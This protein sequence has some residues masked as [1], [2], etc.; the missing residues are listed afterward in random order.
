MSFRNVRTFTVKKFPT[1]TKKSMITFSRCWKGRMQSFKHLA[2]VGKGKKNT[3]KQEQKKSY[4]A[5]LRIC[6]SNSPPPPGAYGRQGP[7]PPTRRRANPSGSGDHSG[8]ETTGK[9][10]HLLMKTVRLGEETRKRR[11]RLPL[12]RNHIQPSR[13]YLRSAPAGAA[14]GASPAGRHRHKGSGSASAPTSGPPRPARVRRA[15]GGSSVP[16]RPPA[17]TRPPQPTPRPGPSRTRTR[18]TSTHDPPRSAAGRKAQNRSAGRRGGSWEVESR[19][20]LRGSGERAA[21]LFASQL[22]ALGATAC[23]ARSRLPSRCSP[24]VPTREAGTPRTGE[25]AGARTLR[26]RG[27]GEGEGSVHPSGGS[28]S[29]FS[30][31]AGGG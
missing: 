3:K 7:I 5:S 2:P 27:R 8:R 18:S 29:E 16:A 12:G 28:S 6:G 31:A 20:W 4:F 23:S 17:P 21:L 11:R 30:P 9:K 24:V 10:N 1:L 25:R 26:R 15:G 14:P 19:P 13:V 22:R